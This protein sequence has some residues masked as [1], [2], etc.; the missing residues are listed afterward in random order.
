MEDNKRVLILVNHDI[1][2]YNFR[3]ELV[4]RLLSEGYEVHISSPP[5]PHTEELE[6]MGAV[7]HETR[8][9]RHGMN[10]LEELK[11]YKV[12]KCMLDEIQPFVVLTY[13]I[14][15]NIYGGLAAEKKDIPFC[16]NITGLGS[17]IN[18]GGLKEILFRNLYRRGLKNAECVFFQNEAN[19][20]YMLANKIVHSPYTVLPGSGVN[21]KNFA[22]E[23]YPKGS[24]KPILTYVG[25]IMK[26]KGM[27]EL[28]DAA[29]IVK[30][31]N[32]QVEFRLIGFFDDEYEGRIKAAEECGIIKHIPQQIDIHPWLKET[33]AVIMPSH[34]EGM[35]NVILE[36]A[37]TGRPVLA[38]DIPG[39]KEAV[40]DGVNGMLF[41]PRDGQK[42][43]DVIQ[44]F[45]LLPY[46][47]K[48][49]MGRAGREKMEQEF[50]RE[51]VVNN[52]I[53]EIKKLEDKQ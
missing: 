3:R 7:F 52:Y 25:R 4:E 36:A 41:P 28:L 53:R 39:C 47:K 14:K 43:A 18:N 35:S 6:K 12:Y 33:H 40:E 30:E 31:N 46:E 21:L 48:V 16:A 9:N 38:S 19:K 8:I 2:I 1:V 10:P 22:Y 32:P 26:D 27:D 49:S 42:M 34:H 11:L 20:N 17:S 5:G 37:S 13:T 50:N 29:R 15:C 24:D 45:L 23:E 51:I 44:N